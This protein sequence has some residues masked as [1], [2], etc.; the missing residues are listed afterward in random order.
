MQPPIHVLE[1][2]R[3]RARLAVTQETAVNGPDGHD[4]AGGRGKERFVGGP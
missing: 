2:R 3:H 4:A 1:P